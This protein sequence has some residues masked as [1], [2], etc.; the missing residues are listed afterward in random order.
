MEQR[1]DMMIADQESESSIRRERSDHDEYGFCK[2]HAYEHDGTRRESMES[3]LAENIRSCRKN[4]G[5][6]SL[7]QKM[8]FL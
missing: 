6:I 7:T 8:Y 1:S 2:Q 3:K 5:H 4:L